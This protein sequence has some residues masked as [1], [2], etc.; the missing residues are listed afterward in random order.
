MPQPCDEV[1]FTNEPLPKR[2]VAGDVGAKN[3]QR[4]VAGQ[5]GMLDQ[6][7]LAHSAGAKQPQNPVTG[8]GLTDPQRHGR[9]LAAAIAAPDHFR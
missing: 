6:V 1:S 7:N 5:S 4:I 3:L 2:S 8:E 9:M